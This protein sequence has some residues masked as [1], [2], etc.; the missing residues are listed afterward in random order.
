MKAF[1][2]ITGNKELEQLFEALP[3][4]LVRDAAGLFVAAGSSAASEMRY[5]YVRGPGNPAKGY[6]GG[7]LIAGVGSESGGSGMQTWVKVFSKA[8]H[9]HLYEYG[10]EARHTAEG[11]D[12]GFVTGRPTFWPIFDRWERTA[13][14]AL[15]DLLRIAGLKVGDHAA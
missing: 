10:T 11:W 9:A 7:N 13:T 6:A 4:D 14:E 3:A 2:R 15:K 8:A 5:T 1:L 12:R